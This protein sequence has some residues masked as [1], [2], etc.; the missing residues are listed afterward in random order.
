MVCWVFF[1]WSFLKAK[2]LSKEK[3]YLQRIPT[4]PNLFHRSLTLSGHMI[5]LVFKYTQEQT[6]AL[7]LLSQLKPA[8]YSPV[9]DLYTCLKTTQST[10]HQLLWCPLLL[11]WCPLQSF[12]KTISIEVHLTRGKFAAHRPD[13]SRRRRRRLPPCPLAIAFIPLKCSSRKL[14]IGCPF[15]RNYFGALTF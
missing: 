5:P 8:L 3:E 2:Y 4:T 7:S 14:Q 13:T 1:S 9:I 10:L 12:N 15:I 11:L 6:F